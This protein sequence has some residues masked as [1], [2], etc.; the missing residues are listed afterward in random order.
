MPRFRTALSGIFI[1]SAPYGGSDKSSNGLRC[2]SI[3]LVKPWHG[4]RSAPSWSSCGRACSS[5][6]EGDGLQD[7]EDVDPLVEGGV[8]GRGLQPVRYTQQGWL[9]LGLTGDQQC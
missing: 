2:D 1:R 9:V 7:K 4:E 5:D 3:P 8:G 6:E